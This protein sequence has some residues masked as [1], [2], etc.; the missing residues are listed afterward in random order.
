MK[1]SELRGTGSVFRFT[2]IQTVKSKAYIVSAV[3]LLVLSLLVAPVMQLINGSG[4][5]K[6]IEKSNIETVYICNGL[7]F[8]TKGT[9]ITDM[10]GMEA[11]S[12][13]K[14]EDLE[15]KLPESIDAMSAEEITEV[16]NKADEENYKKICEQLE[17]KGSECK[18]AVLHAYLDD[19]RGIVV[20][21]VRVAGSEVKDDECR[22]LLGQI[23][24]NLDDYKIK[25]SGLSEEELTILAYDY[26]VEMNY[27]G[28]D[29]KISAAVD[30][31]IGGTQ[32]GVAYA[33]MFIVGML[34]I[35]SATQVATAV[36]TDKSSRVVELLLTSVRPMAL[37]LG[38]ILAMLVATIGQ[39]VVLFGAFA[40]SNKVTGMR[41]AT[42]TSY[43]SSIIPKGILS[44]LTF[45][46]AVIIF[47]LVALGLVFYATLA[48]LC[49][50]MVSKMEELQDTLKY[51][52]F[53]SMIGLYMAIFAIISMQRS[54]T[55]TF[56]RF[57]E[58]FPL[59]SPM[60]TP[61][62]LIIGVVPVSY[63]LIAIALLIVLDFLTL[64]FAAGVYEG[65]I[66]NMGTNLKA[67]DVIA[68]A[69]N[70]K[71]KG[72]TK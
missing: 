15:V 56:V 28:E 35:M 25:I 65:L 36:V 66:T 46:N 49:G 69:R 37:L 57:C 60:T 11:F 29:G 44:N 22:E 45:V 55:G 8:L 4:K 14:F 38:K 6:K 34:C 72:G 64:R 59:T 17:E 30:T 18:D 20:E 70:K 32:F 40:I 2:L 54:S 1:S 67:K 52:T 43:L 51:F 12:G 58:M 68:M 41:S 13:V 9:D 33:I 61:G 42:G 50:A 19:E 31:G 10:T 27:L 47:A 16:V 48:G 39:Y 24:K 21:L 3:I 63:A 71:N 7:P 23:C 62:A 5:E 53:T 26:T